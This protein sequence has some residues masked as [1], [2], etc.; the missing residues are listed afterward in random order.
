MRT[1]FSMKRIAIL[2]LL[3]LS[4]STAK[5][6]MKTITGGNYQNTNGTPCSGCILY[7]Q[8]GTDATVIGTGQIVPSTNAYTL[9]VN[10]NVPANSNLWANDQMQPPGLTY[11]ATLTLPGGGQVWGPEFLFISGPSPISLTQIVPVASSSVFFVAPA[12]L[13]AANTFT[14]SNTFTQQ[15]V[16]TV[17]VG[18]P[19]FSISS[20]TLVNNLNAQFHGGFAAPNSAPVGVSDT[21]PL[22]N[23]TLDGASSG[24]SVTLL[25]SAGPAAAITGNSSPQNI[26]SCTIPANV[27]A[28]LKGMRVTATWSHSTGTAAVTYGMSLNG[29][30]CW[31]SNNSAAT[32]GGLSQI[33]NFIETGST[34]GNVMTQQGFFSF[35]TT[36]LTGLAWTSS[37]TLAVTF[38]VA[39]TDA[40]TPLFF[41]VELIQ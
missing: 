33:A 11:K 22:S 39:N 40:V 4:A 30:A 14:G 8:L 32:V 7:L 23:K 28:N 12:L 16:S 18:T 26:F 6:Q 15:I 41:L 24:N 3:A 21:Q 38:N 35:T 25:C 20:P 5:A 9:D 1:L 31:P 19:P 36:T 37:Q 2:L 17:T 10:G 13:G 29:V 27:V 34:T